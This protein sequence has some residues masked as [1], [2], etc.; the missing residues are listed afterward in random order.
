MYDNHILEV[1][2]MDIRVFKYCYHK[3]HSYIEK[4]QN[5]YRIKKR[6]IYN[7]PWRYIK[8]EKEN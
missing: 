8:Y 6:F 4:N 2:R 5:N 7:H 1:T 3:L